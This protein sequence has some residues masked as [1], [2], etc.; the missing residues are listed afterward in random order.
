MDTTSQAADAQIT[1]V[2]RAVTTTARQDGVHAVLSISQ[3]YPTTV[4]DLWH[5]CTDAERLRR[6]FGEVTGDLRLGGTYQVQDNAHGTVTTCE[7]PHRFTAT[8]E[9]GG[10]TS[11]V[12]VEITAEDDGARFTLTH[13]SDVDAEFWEQFGPSAGGIGWDLGLLGL[14]THVTIGTGTPPEETAW[15]TSPSGTE[16]VHAVAREW[17]AL[18]VDHPPAEAAGRAAAFFAGS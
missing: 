5:A 8:W 9:Y 17:S 7:P 15:M 12:V 13:S 14:A 2:R 11:D 18:A 16:F 6:W 10:E 4:E 3:A 1:E